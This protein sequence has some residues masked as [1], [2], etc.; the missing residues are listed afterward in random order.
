MLARKMQSVEERLSHELFENSE[1]CVVGD[2]FVAVI[3][4]CYSFLGYGAS[5]IDYAL[6]ATQPSA[7]SLQ[8]LRTWV[9]G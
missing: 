8:Y 4:I 1:R 2:D 7:L 5:F 9:Q 3:Y 6:A